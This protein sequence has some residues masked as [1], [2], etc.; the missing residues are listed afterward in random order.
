MDK[1]EKWSKKQRILLTFVG[2]MALFLDKLEGKP[3]APQPVTTGHI[4]IVD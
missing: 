4:K 3:P 1:Q 2:L